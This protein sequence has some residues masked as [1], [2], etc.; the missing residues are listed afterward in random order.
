MAGKKR[1]KKTGK[2]TVPGKKQGS[3]DDEIMAF[4]NAV[5]GFFKKLKSRKLKLSSPDTKKV[6][7]GAG[8]ILIIALLG[9]Q[10]F[11]AYK[12]E[13]KMTTG[14]E[15][16]EHREEQGTLVAGK[17]LYTLEPHKPEVRKYTKIGGEYVE[18]YKLD[19]WPKWVAETSE[20]DTLILERN[21]EKLKRYREGRL[22]STIRIGELRTARNFLIDSENNIY[23]P[24]PGDNKIYKY[25]LKGKFITKFPDEN[26]FRSIFKIFRDIEDNIYALEMGKPYA[27]R[28]YDKKGDF[29][30]KWELPLDEITGAEA[31]VV[32]HDG[33][34]YVNDMKNYSILV[35][36][37]DG[38]KVG[39]FGEDSSKKYNIGIPGQFSGGIDNKIYVNRL[40][41]KP[42]EY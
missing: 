22:I 2:K 40:T 29:I 12:K 27:I 28:I 36:N 13:L 10:V 30:K 25:S 18:T 23:I 26:E 38:K 11:F 34:V 32:T 19:D 41:F 14:P 17:H 1:G 6:L 33:N 4:V 35:F 31:V 16:I 21:S 5:G 24:S 15:L 42:L 3:D 8:V 9:L 20:G 7:V 39:E 37:N